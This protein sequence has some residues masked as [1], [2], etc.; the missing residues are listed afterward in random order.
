[1][2]DAV[3]TNILLNDLSYIA[4]FTNLS[5]GTGEAAVKKVDLSALTGPGGVVP[6]SLSVV[7]VEWTISG[8]PYVKIEWDHTA[9]DTA[10]I[11]GEGCGE[12]DF[13]PYGSLLDPGSTGGTGDILFTAPAGSAGDSYSITLHLTKRGC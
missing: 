8:F 9:N 3:T 1:M 10:V 5:D 11:L 6:T 2:T 7:R 4:H 12:L 13:N